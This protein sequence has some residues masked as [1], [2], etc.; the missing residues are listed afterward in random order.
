MKKAFSLLAIIS[1]CINIYGQ[2]NELYHFWFI[3]PNKSI[4]NTTLT[5]AISIDNVSN[6]SVFAYA[7]AEQMIAFRKLGY[8][9][10]IITEKT[11]SSK[12]TTMAT[13]IA[14]MANWDKYPTYSVY[15]GLMKKFEQDFPALCRLDSIGTTPGGHKI[16][17][18]KLSKNVTINEPEV[19]A[20]YTSSMHGDETTGFISMLRLIDSLLTGYSSSTRIANMLDN[21]AIFIN[22]SANPDGTY[23]PDNNNVYNARRT[24]NDGFDLNRNFPD[25]KLGFFT[26][27][28]PETQI[29]M[30]FA[31]TRHFNISANFHD[32]VEL[33]N[34]PWDSW[35]SSQRLHPDNNW[36]IHFSRQYADSAQK[37]G[38][39][40]YFTYESN[41]ITNG[42]DWYVVAGGRQDY[43]NW[44]HHCREVTI[45]LYRDML[46]DVEKLNNL[47]DYN[48]E[49]F[50]GYLEAGLQGFNGVI[51]NSEGEP[52]KAKVFIAG[53]DAD[54]SF[55][56]SNS[57]TGFYA[58]PIEPGTW[59]VTYSANGYQP[60]T[61][62][63]TIA[64]WKSVIKKNIELK[65][66]YNVNF[67]VKESGNPLEN[68][69]ISFNS[70]IKQTLSNGEA[71][72]LGIPQGDAYD[73]T[74]SLN[75]Y[76][77]AS[78]QVNINS[79]K[80]ITISLIPETTTVYT[81]SFNVAN[82]SNP[83]EDAT[84]LF[85]GIEQET[86]TSGLVPFTN[87]IQNANYNYS[88][89]KPGYQTISSQ[90]DVIGD[91]TLNIELVPFLYT[92]DVNVKH[93]GAGISYVNVSFNGIENQTISNGTTFF[94]NILYGKKYNYSISKTGYKTVNGQID[95]TNNKT[96]NIELIP[97][98]NIIF[99]L[100]DKG[101][102]LT[103]AKILFNSLISF[104]NSSGIA[105]FSNV[106][107]GLN[108]AYTISLTNYHNVYGLVDAVDNKNINI[109]LTSVGAGSLVAEHNIL[110]IW[111]NPFGN[112]L[113]IGIELEKPAYLSFAIYSLDGRLI[114]KPTDRLGIKGVNSILISDLSN[115]N[116]GSYIVV[117]RVDNKS[118]SQIIQH[119]R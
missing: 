115:M 61:H 60:Q 113:T 76:H 4:I 52:I 8:K 75:G 38:F 91:K 85:N 57:S 100:T 41:G 64:N 7:N 33:V 24:N 74:I 53:H 84:I 117:L 11:F 40:D 66:V 93:L 5:R 37:Y 45:E 1:F 2:Q 68:A 44:W 112:S 47:W 39:A 30:D 89:S 78:G 94:N 107:Y 118:Y 51:T 62:T 43:M 31:S 3:E 71:I 97:I 13:T 99:N 81:V 82:Q 49:S 28:Q 116:S 35:T 73:Y 12:S 92:L 26:T 14:Q 79:D 86:S 34:Y 108:Y 59:D 65:P 67:D 110:N 29:M 56:Y 106:P 83:V 72:Y 9:Y 87:T 58:R 111:P 88:V 27:I 98:Y 20:F 10:A 105:T 54:S 36:Y 18:V 16:Y 63:I 22:P 69:S 21:M 102:P 25:P 119:I 23:R 104:T 96:L 17:V 19:E 42:G 70:I 95:I 103:N 90:T 114:K 32:G 15:R 48:K 80:T 50:L 6:D 77:S 109:E 46:I 101:V 55:V